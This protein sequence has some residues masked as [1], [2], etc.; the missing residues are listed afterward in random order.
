[1]DVIVATA[2]PGLRLTYISTPPPSLPV[3]SGSRYFRVEK[4]GDFWES[5]C[6]SHVI[7]FYVPAEL[8]KL[9]LELLAIK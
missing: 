7:A 9:R 8:N 3:R 2:L 1:M 6:R 4:Q 5:V